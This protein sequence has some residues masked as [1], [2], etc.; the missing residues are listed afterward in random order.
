MAKFLA[1]LKRRHVF[2]V[3]AVYGAAGFLVVQ[4]ADVFVPAL[5][6]PDAVTTGVALLVIL[7]FPIALVITWAFEVTPAGVQRTVNA[8]PGELEAIAAERAS[9]RWPIGL[10]A[11]AGAVLIG[12]SAWWLWSGRIGEGRSYESIA[13]LPMAN[14]SGSDE[15][16]YFGDGLAEELLN[17]LAGVDGLKVAARTSSFAFKE[18]GVDVRTIAD[19][20]GVQTVLEGSVRRSPDNIRVTLQLIDAADGFHIWSEN[21]DRPLASLLDLQDEIASAV[22]GSLLPRLRGRE[23]LLVKGATDDLRAYDAYLK[24]RQQW[25]TREVAQLWE[26]L[27]NMRFAVRRDTAFALAWSGLADAI[28]ALAARD[29]LGR[30]LLPEARRA[31]LRALV[32]APD[33]AEAWASVGVLAAFYDGDV[34]T[35]EPALRRA[36]ELKAYPHAYRHLGVLVQSMGRIAEARPLLE[37]GVELDPLS[38]NEHSGLARVLLIAGEPLAARER[39]ETA[40]RLS[41][42]SYTY[43]I[44]AYAADL[45]LTGAE[46]ESVAERYARIR[47][48]DDPTAWR[49]VGRAVVDSTLW[50]PAREFLATRSELPAVHRHRLGLALGDDEAA[51]AYLQNIFDSGIVIIQIGTESAYDR[52]RNDPRFIELVRRAGLPNGYNPV[53]QT[54]RWP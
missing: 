7:G 27:E 2:R 37:R 28:D 23:E 51:I 29:T 47:G 11:L 39:F 5:R 53:T 26:A 3:M 8:A 9:R 49:L 44:L 18:S 46:A 20:L 1:E 36:I 30:E 33:L 10:A 15:F 54:A 24:G 41:P 52:L 12:L 45:G 13:V 42:L 14:L 32:L 21:Y 16:D 34:A 6:L 43:L 50:A 19:S 31:A 38:P 25:H 4:V 48:Y 17:A 22:M 40:A 35:G